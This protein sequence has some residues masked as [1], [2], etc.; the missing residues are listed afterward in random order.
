MT[1]TIVSPVET[2]L[3]NQRIGSLQ[4]RV[5]A[6]CGLI[7]ICDGFDVNSIGIVV[8][9]L[10]HAWNLPG[11]AF[12]VAFLWSSIGIL[13]GAISAGPIGDRVGRKPL[14]IGSLVIFGAASLGSAFAGS[15]R[16]LPTLRLGRYGVDL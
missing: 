7:Q 2:A 6:L 5:V 14:L 12:T 4:I 11:P 9:S 1:E 8:P 10:T 16:A 3:E 15:L 13:L